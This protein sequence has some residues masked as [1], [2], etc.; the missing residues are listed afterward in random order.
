M[1]TYLV[2]NVAAARKKYNVPYP[3]LYKVALSE[4]DQ[5]EADAFNSIQRAHQNTLVI[6]P[7]IPS[8]FVY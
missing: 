1:N 4:K 5:K 7:I 3:N 6:Y 2:I 8:S